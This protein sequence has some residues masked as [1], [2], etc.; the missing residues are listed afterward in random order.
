MIRS[1]KGKTPQ[2]HPSAAIAETAVLIGDVTLEKNTSIWYGVTARGDSGPIVIGEG[3]NIQDHCVLHN[4]AGVPLQVGKNCVVGHGAILHSCTVGDSCLIGMGAILLTGCRI[5]EGSLVGAG[6]LVT[7]KMNFP[8]HSMIMG[9]PA[10]AVR[11]LTE[12]E[13]AAT[14][15]E[16]KEY[17]EKAQD[18]LPSAGIG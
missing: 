2:I 1:F 6:A 18:E 8:P 12:E 4:D 16:A 9:V 17:W 3:S 11:T 13:I 5:G 10:K 15:T 14:L 7:G